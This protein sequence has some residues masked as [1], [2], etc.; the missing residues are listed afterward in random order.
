MMNT[1][2]SESSEARLRV[3]CT[4]PV[5]E[6]PSPK[7]AKPTAFFP[8]RRWE[9]AAP[10]TLESIAPRWLIIGSERAD[11]S[12]WW[13]LPSRALVGLPALAKYWLR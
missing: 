1:T 2:G 13:M 11:G 8:K 9:S 4:S 6:E 3:S 7:M 5:L 12:P 10:A